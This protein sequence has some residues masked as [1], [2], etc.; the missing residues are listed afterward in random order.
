MWRKARVIFKHMTAYL[1]PNFV[2][3]ACKREHELSCNRV[4]VETN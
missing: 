4:F 1:L 2:G 3:L